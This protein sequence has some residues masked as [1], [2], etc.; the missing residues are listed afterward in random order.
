M[1]ILNKTYKSINVNVYKI[2]YEK[3]D[4]IDLIKQVV[5]TI[6][7]RIII[8][9]ENKGNITSGFYHSKKFVALYVSEKNQNANYLIQYLL[10][11]IEN[12][13]VMHKYF[14]KNNQHIWIIKTQGNNQLSKDVILFIKTAVCISFIKSLNRINF[15]DLYDF[16]IN[17]FLIVHGIEFI[18]KPDKVVFIIRYTKKSHSIDLFI[19]K[20]KF[21]KYVNNEFLT[22]KE[23]NKGG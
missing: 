23:N 11:R 2:I 7:V 16:N 12:I 20:L 9:L 17:E 4:D 21:L 15:K 10:N 13:K 19:K 1:K 8:D 5:N 14:Q 6:F 3:N 22:N 18:Q